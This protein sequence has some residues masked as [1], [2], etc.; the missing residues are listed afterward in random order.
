MNG[1]NCT[2]GTLVSTGTISSTATNSIVT[3]INAT[4]LVGGT[5]TVYLCAKDLVGN[6][7]SV[8]ATITKDITPP[9]V[10]VLSYAPSTVSNEDFSV[11]WSASENGTYALEV[12]G[13]ELVGSN[14]TNVVGTF[15][16][17]NIISTINNSVLVNGV[18]TIKVKFTDAASNG[19]VLSDPA[20]VTKDNIPPQPPQSVTLAD[21]DYVGNGGTPCAALGNPRSGATGRDFRID[22]TLPSNT[23][24]IQEYQVYVVP[25]GQSLNST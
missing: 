20:P 14:G 4:S 24:S 17:A 2:D 15:T 6:V 8:T 11:T 16:G 13:V 1:T 23:G 5:N 22:F 19:P 9:T 3:D 21:C 25:F 7:G 18:N 12:N 10:T